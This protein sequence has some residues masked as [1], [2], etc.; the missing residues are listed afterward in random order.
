MTKNKES[1]LKMIIGFITVII[2]LTLFI[3]VFFLLNYSVCN[4]SNLWLNHNKIDNLY[5]EKQIK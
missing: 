3:A 1:I 5:L 2:T 4:Y